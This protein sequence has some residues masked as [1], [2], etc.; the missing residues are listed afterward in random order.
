MHSVLFFDPVSIPVPRLRIYRR[1][2]YRKGV[3]CL[4][5][6]Q[7]AEADRYI[8]EA[9]SLMH[10]KGAAL[11][12]PVLERDASGVSLPGNIRFESRKLS[13]LLGHCREIVLM[14]ATAGCD[15][16]DAIRE[17]IAG[18]HVTRGV[19][20]DATASEMTDAVLDWIMAY[21]NRTLRRE[22]NRLLPKRFS[23]GYGDFLLENQ[24][25]MYNLLQ[26]DLMGVRM[27]ESCLLIPEKS[28]TAVSGI[29]S[30]GN[31]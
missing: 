11:R 23:A 6:Q 8:E 10:L 9:Q 1:L 28:V 29:E 31:G 18:C 19:V 13:T 16:M 2:G 27:T 26:L 7:K 20:F 25:I 21:F 5:P 30:S 14:G 3:T 4:L 22:N 24:K 17:D 15:I 12:L